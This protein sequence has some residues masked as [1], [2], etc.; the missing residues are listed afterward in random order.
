LGSLGDTSTL[1]D[2]AVVEEITAG[3]V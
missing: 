2:P 1:L 3:R